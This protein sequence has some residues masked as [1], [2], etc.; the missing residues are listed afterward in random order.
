M[1]TREGEEEGGKRKR[2]G[3]SKGG[4]RERSRRGVEGSSQAISLDTG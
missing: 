2:I 1:L 4:K 3:G